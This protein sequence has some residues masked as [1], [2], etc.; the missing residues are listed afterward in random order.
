MNV[1]ESSDIFIVDPTPPVLEYLPTILTNYTSVSGS[2]AEWDKSVLRIFWKFSDAESPVVRHTITLVTHHEGHTPVEHFE[3][4]A[5]NKVTITLDGNERLHDG[6]KY[7]VVITSCNAAELCT[8]ARSAYILIDS[9]PPHLGGFKPPL[10]WNNT[11]M[12][13]SVVQLTW[14]G[15]ADQESGIDT[16]YLTVS[17]SYTEHELTSGIIVIPTNSSLQ[18]YQ[19]HVS[20]SDAVQADDKLILTIWARNNAGLNSSVA[21]VTVNALSTFANRQKFSAQSGILELQKHSCDIH[22]CNKDC[23][24]A[25][26]G[27]PCLEVSTNMTC[28]VLTE[29]DVIHYGLPVVDVFGGLTH[30]LTQISASSSCLSGSW[31]LRNKTA[32]LKIRRFEFSMGLKDQLVGEGIV[33]LKSTRPWQD[34]GKRQETVYCLPGNQT[35][36]HSESYIIYVRAWYGPDMYSQFES[37]P[38][39]IDHTPPH[40]VRG[41]FIKDSDATC[42]SDYDFIDWFDSIAA[43]WDKT[44]TESQGKIISFSVGLGTSPGC[45]YESCFCFVV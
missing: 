26:L 1:S 20:L 32:L 21:R 12:N 19:A 34:V 6:D 42:R 16:F 44:F 45:K 9:T 23:T 38:I 17:R 7:S 29:T 36:I 40:V 18:E 31:T 5:E 37:Q 25:V 24:C 2:K 39:T 33:D 8:T 13:S 35:L 22:F 10:T 11:G 27:Q 4:G 15:F 30:Q 3:M 43:C 14:Y 41:G 28:T